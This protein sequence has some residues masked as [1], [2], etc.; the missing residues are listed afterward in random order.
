VKHKSIKVAK[1]GGT[2]PPITQVLALRCLRSG[3]GASCDFHSHPF[4]EFTLVTDDS[5][6]NGWA[7]GRTPTATGILQLNGRV[8]GSF[9]SPLRSWH[10]CLI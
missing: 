1:A 3:A 9:T 10:P 5:T 8:S 2:Q 6:V 7:L 4:P